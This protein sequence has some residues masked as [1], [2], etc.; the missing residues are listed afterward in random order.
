MP[1][2]TRR[3][4]I[5][6]VGVILFFLI[7]VGGPLFYIWYTS[8]PPACTP[9]SE[10]PVGMT[11]GPC[12]I[13][14][15][16]ALQPEGV[17]WARTFLVRAGTADAVAYIDNPNQGAGVL[18]VPYEL[19]IYDNEN[20]LVQDITGKTFIMP[21]G[22]TP[23]FVGGINV[24]NRSPRYAQFKL[25]G[26]LLWQKVESG[27]QGI[28][29]SNIQTSGSASASTITALATNSSVS[30]VSNVTFVATVFD[31]AGNAIATSQ[32]ALRQIAAG[33]TQQIY[34]TWPTP[35]SSPVGSVD[36]IPVVAPVPIES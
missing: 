6:L 2:A 25:T 20:A 26:A 33:V 35:F 32:T 36:I 17:L 18:D 11:T 1:W 19:D 4:A 30:D 28:K 29:V 31:P 9:G 12:Y 23:I 22:I 21:G 14:D 27:A 10:R 8:I 34:F 16:S 13:L 7:V 5:Y 3:R 24:G 15:A